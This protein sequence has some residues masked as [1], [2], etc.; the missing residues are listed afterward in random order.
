MKDAMTARDIKGLTEDSMLRTVLQKAA[1][2]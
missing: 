2:D 1:R